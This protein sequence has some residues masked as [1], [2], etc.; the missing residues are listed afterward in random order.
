MY[1]T[2]IYFSNVE[3]FISEITQELVKADNDGPLDPMSVSSVVLHA[4]PSASP[5]LLSPAIPR[6]T[7]D[8]HAES[9]GTPWSNDA[10]IPLTFFQHARLTG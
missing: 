3:M 8:S 5:L 2:L 6:I 9:P 4:S 10:S 1:N 7:A